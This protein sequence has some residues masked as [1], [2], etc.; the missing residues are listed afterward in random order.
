MSVHNMVFHM[1]LTTG[2]HSVNAVN[3]PLMWY[4]EIHIVTKHGLGWLTVRIAMDMATSLNLLG[5]IQY[6][7]LQEIKKCMDNIIITCPRISCPQLYDEP[8]GKGLPD[9]GFQVLAVHLTDG[10]SFPTFTST[11]HLYRLF[12]H[13]CAPISVGRIRSRNS[14]P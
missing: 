3:Y 12:L 10:Q 14:Y 1:H 7:G 2:C 4:W 5:M 6:I 8:M 11:I 9:P 13:C